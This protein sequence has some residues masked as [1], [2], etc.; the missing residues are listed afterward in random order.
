MP[1][2][3]E[4]ILI[5]GTNELLF[6]LPGIKYPVKV[7]LAVDSGIVTVV[8]SYPLKKERGEMN[9]YYDEKDKVDALYL[10]PGHADPGTS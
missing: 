6:E 1:Y 10:Q 8:T 9:V 4:A 7:V 2:I 3:Q 5:E